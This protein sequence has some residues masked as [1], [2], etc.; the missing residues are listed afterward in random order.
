MINPIDIPYLCFQI[1]DKITKDVV[2]QY[3][4]NV[5][6]QNGGKKE[7]VV[8]RFNEYLKRF[9]GVLIACQHGD[10]DQVW[11]LFVM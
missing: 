2:I 4:E 1:Y 5:D 6:I 7:V 3:L 11:S 10:A 9:N 8:H